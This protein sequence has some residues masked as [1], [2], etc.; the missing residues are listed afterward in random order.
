MK[1]TL[2]N[3]TIPD[4]TNEFATQIS[5]DFYKLR[6]S[7]KS[8]AVFEI[9]IEILKNRDFT[10]REDW[11]HDSYEELKD[12]LVSQLTDSAKHK[13]SAEQLSIESFYL[14]IL[15]ATLVH[16]NVPI[17]EIIGAVGKYQLDN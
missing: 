8:L 13:F 15:T 7:Y 4:I 6:S 14:G 2:Q 11:A 12:S 9:I 5:S 16:T 1:S 3:H 17:P 10:F